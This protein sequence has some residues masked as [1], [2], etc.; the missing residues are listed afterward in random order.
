MTAGDESAKVEDGKSVGRGGW[1]FTQFACVDNW[2]EG[3]DIDGWQGRWSD[4]RAVRATIA[5]V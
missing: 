5:Q 2:V 3:G 4:H 1:A